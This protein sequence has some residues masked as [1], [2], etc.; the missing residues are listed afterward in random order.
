MRPKHHDKQMEMK[1]EPP[2]NYYGEKPVIYDVYK[3]NDIMGES[4]YTH[5]YFNENK[6]II[7]SVHEQT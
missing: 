3:S 6:L 7:D 2:Y 1:K 4:V 5:F